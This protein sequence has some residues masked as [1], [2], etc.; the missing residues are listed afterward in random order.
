MV[1]LRVVRRSLRYSSL[2]W[3]VG[4]GAC[5]SV[6]GIEDLHDGPRPGSGGDDS[7]G[8]TDA[9]AGKNS[10]AG[11]SSGGGT[12]STGGGSDATGGTNAVGGSKP[13]G[14]ANATGG[15]VNE[16]GA[17]GEPVTN[18][19]TVHGTLIDYWGH[20]LSNVVINIA[21]QQ[22]PT[23]KDGKFTAENVP[24]E[25]DATLRVTREVNTRQ[26]GWA[27]IGLTRRDPT[28]QIYQSLDDQES[29]GYVKST[30]PALLANDV[31]S[32]ALGTV[33]GTRQKATIEPNTQYGTYFSAYWQGGET[34][35]GT[36][37]GLLWAKDGTTDLPT[38]YKGY[39]A[40]LIALAAG[41][42]LDVTLDL[43]KTDI[44]ANAIA[45]TVAPYAKGERVNSMFVRFD[46]G[47]SLQVVE[48]AP[49][50]ANAFSYLAPVLP[51]SSITIAASEGAGYED[52]YSIVHK[53]GLAPGADPGTLTIP[54]PATLV[55]PTAV[56]TMVDENTEFSFTGSA[57]SKGAF[58]VHMEATQFYDYFYIVTAKKKF[59]LPDVPSFGWESGRVFYWRVETHGNFKT[60]DEMAGAKGFADEFTG[61][62]QFTDYTAPQPSTNQ[63][64]GSFTMSAMGYFT[65]K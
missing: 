59:K 14:G 17:G 19:P 12:D 39:D 42:P 7:S 13:T 52:V 35:M 2:L 10:S 8:G 57:D 55:S 44:V 15:S 33:E 11:K 38:A 60:V 61:C 40:K 20:P 34:V 27:F 1:G 64:S 37:H 62:T 63:G 45:G 25:Y 46:T 5:T 22:V 41:T 43:K 18:D 32:A 30:S 53:D 47:G 58:V 65:R 36:M 23:D 16:A 24:A 26:Y 9:S 29:D 21:G 6:L 28:L 3:L 51:K 50:P 48:D 56:A 54:A 49:P 4:L 31:A